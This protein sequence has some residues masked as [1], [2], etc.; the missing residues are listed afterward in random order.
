MDL[1]HILFNL[2]FPMSFSI[3][4]CAIPCC[5]LN[6]LLWS[7][8]IK[9][10]FLDF[11]NDQTNK[12]L[13]YWDVEL[14]DNSV[15]LYIWSSKN[16]QLSKGRQIK[17]LTCT[18]KLLCPVSPMR[19]FLIIRDP[20]PGTLFCHSDG[21]PLTKFQFWSVT[22]KALD[23]LGLQGVKFATHSFRIVAAS[24][25]A[26]LDMSSDD[27]QKNGRWRSKPIDHMWDIWLNKSVVVLF[28]MQFA[29]WWDT[30]CWSA[31]TA[32]C[33]GRPAKPG[34]AIS[35]ASW[36][37]Q[38]RPSLSGEVNVACGGMGSCSCCLAKASV[39]PLMFWLYIW[40]AMIWVL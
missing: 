21:S 14:H 13:L 25:A 11:K 35:E 18:D 17:W 8:K 31:D 33:S 22:S 28:Q 2:A 23:V 10:A 40:A 34:G 9:Q 36:G 12:G 39:C 6:G 38:I 29:Q 5:S 3:W 27:I 15:H 24:T 16:D 7:F 30:V 19:S 32:W 26:A 4:S 20:L 37:C 1:P